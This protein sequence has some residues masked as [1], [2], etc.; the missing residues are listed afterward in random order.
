MTSVLAKKNGQIVAS[1]Q[2]LPFIVFLFFNHSHFRF[3][4]GVLIDL[5]F[6]L[7]EN[8]EWSS[9][10]VKRIRKGFVNRV[11]VWVIEI[12][13]W[14]TD[15]MNDVSNELRAHGFNP[16][17]TNWFLYGIEAVFPISLVSKG[18]AILNV[19]VF[20]INTSEIGTTFRN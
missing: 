17:N 6:I 3:S 11:K 9:F 12:Y 8:R 14:P 10:W 20:L 19:W 1:F 4:F 7:F 16:V 15:V 13:K 18:A 2:F 5:K